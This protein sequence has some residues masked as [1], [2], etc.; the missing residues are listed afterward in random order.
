MTPPPQ[1]PSEPPLEYDP[2]SYELDAN[3]YPVY[4]RLR[5]EAPVYYNERLDFYALT[6]FED[7]HR[8][9]ID[10]QTFSSA[11]GTVL[12]L[13]D[14]RVGG[15]LIIFMDPPRQTRLR[16]LVSKTFTPRRMAALEGA[17]REIARGYLDALIGAGD[18]DF[19]KDFSAK[20]PMDVISALLGIPAA[21]RDT[22]RGWSNDVLHRD[23][24]NPMPPPRTLAAMKEL[25]DYFGECLDERRRRPRDDMMSD[26]IRAE[27]RDDAGELQRLS[28]VEIKGFIN[29]LA[30]A[31]NE[32]VTKLLATAVYQLCQH[33]DQRKQLVEEPSGIPGAVVETPRYDPPSQYQGRTLTREVAL[34]GALLPEG[35]KLLLI[36]AA[37]GRDERQ[38]ADPDR[39]DVNRDVNFHL[40]FG[41]GQHV[42]LGKNLALMESRIALEEFLARFPSYEVDESGIEWMHSSNVRGFSGLPLRF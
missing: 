36:N 15:P 17:I 34:H 10:W 31:G 2:Y 41:H 20:F 7:C 6:R 37:S 27:L 24:G 14:T 30:T 18:C 42:C 21:D 38:Y 39:F 4:K 35:A 5:D 9:F 13:M 33:P 3:P 11:R 1:A 22:V 28:D 25:F 26:L 8:A 19:V 23:A 16:N 32:T 40:N 29:L 12:E